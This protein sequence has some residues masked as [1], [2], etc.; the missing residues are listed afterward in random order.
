VP[1]APCDAFTQAVF[2]KERPVI[3]RSFGDALVW[4]GDTAAGSAVFERGV[5]EGAWP[6][7]PHCRPAHPRPVVGIPLHTQPAR[8]VF[9]HVAVKLESA[10]GMIQREFEAVND[11]DIGSSDVWVR[12]SAGLH[13]HGST[14]AWHVLLLMV[15]GQP[16]QKGCAAMKETCALLMSLP[17]VRHLRDGQVNPLELHAHASQLAPFTLC[18]AGEAEPHGPGNTRAA[19]RGSDESAPAPAAARPSAWTRQLTDAGGIAGL[20]RLDGQPVV[21]FRV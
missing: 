8:A 14:G 18:V 3:Y 15:N 19:T 20:A 5:R 10:L 12:E 17:S 2:A 1:T 11:D 4:S 21:V 16:Q 9:P 6:Y 13:S 7:G